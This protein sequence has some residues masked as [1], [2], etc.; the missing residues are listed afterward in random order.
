ML[1]DLYTLNNLPIDTNE[2]KLKDNELEL[3]ENQM[4]ELLASAKQDL[5][6]RIVDAQ[7]STKNFGLVFQN[8]INDQNNE[9]IK[10]QIQAIEKEIERRRDM[11]RINSAE[12]VD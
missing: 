10:R 5:M 4:I 6:V 9:F 12:D 11:I 2:G 3:Y 7:L 1:D 8:H